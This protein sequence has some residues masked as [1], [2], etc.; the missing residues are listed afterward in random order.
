[1]ILPLTATMPQMG[2]V[3]KGPLL[4]LTRREGDFEVKLVTI[5]AI[6]SAVRI[7]DAAANE[8][9]GR[10]LTKGQY[11]R[12]NRLRRD[13]HDESPDCWLHGTGFCLSA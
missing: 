5:V 11:P 3:G 2:T 1:M 13:T 8:Q 9:I 4:L 7:R 6:Y 12:L 10:A